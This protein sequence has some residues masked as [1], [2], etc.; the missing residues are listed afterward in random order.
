MSPVGSNPMTLSGLGSTAPPPSAPSQST[1]SLSLDAG[2]RPLF[3]QSESNTWLW[4]LSA[5]RPG[6]WA[7]HLAVVRLLP[8]LPASTPSA[9]HPTPSSNEPGCSLALQ[10]P[11]CA[12]GPALPSRPLNHRA[13]PVSQAPLL[14]SVEQ[15]D[16][17]Y[18]TSLMPT[19]R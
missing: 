5:S 9:T 7:V 6:C 8:V 3:P 16:A 12:G 18:W 19:T 1:L 13:L 15:L 10:G 11:S 17:I 4:G 2:S 14:S